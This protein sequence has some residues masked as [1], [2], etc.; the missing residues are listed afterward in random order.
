MTYPASD[1]SAL[2]PVP[3]AQIGSYAIT[4]VA[5]SSGSTPS[6]ARRTC[7]CT[8]VSV[9]PAS[10]SSSVSPTHTIGVIPCAQHALHLPVHDAVVLA[11][12]LPCAR[13][14][15]RSR[16]RPCSACEH[17]EARPRR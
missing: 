10:R 9:P 5:A 6:N 7:C 4:A 2:R 14:G 17:R 15:R 12:E 16:T 3:I 8:F 11:E 13:S 1:G